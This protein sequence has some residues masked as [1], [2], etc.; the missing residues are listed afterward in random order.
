M[1]PQWILGLMAARSLIRRIPIARI[2][3]GGA[4]GIALW[5][6]VFAFQLLPGKAA[7]TPGLFVFMLA[8]IGI[9]ISPL[10]S[11]LLGLLAIAA[12]SV[13]VVA[14]T[15]VSNLVASR[16]VREDQLPDSGVHAIV[17]LSAGLNPDSTISSEGLDHLITGL[18]LMRAGRSQLLVTTTLNRRFPTGLVSSEV[19]Q[20]RIIALFG[21]GIR[22]MRVRPVVST[23][24]EAIASAELL[25]PRRVRQ[26]VVIASPM[27]TRRACRAFEAV[28][29]VVT[30]IPA[31]SRSPGGRAPGPWPR[32]RL[33][34]FGEW[35]YEVVATGV[36]RMKGFM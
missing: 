1:K 36:Y 8:G 17:V 26:I 25:L 16:W 4:V 18:D 9:R 24:D 2:V 3:E 35:V 27:H 10:G 12:A 14:E 13:F 33:T 6:I 5:C 7:D 28:G 22:W 20:S 19:D 11:Y 23:R 32:D 30:C 31:K 34:V 15:S 21:N 29:F